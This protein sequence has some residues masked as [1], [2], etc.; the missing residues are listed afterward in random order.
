MV[1]EELQQRYGSHIARRVQHDLGRAEFNLVDLDQLP[2]YLEAR[3]EK[4]ARDY[5]MVMENPLERGN[6]RCEVLQKLWREAEDIAY[7]L[8]IAEDVSTAVRATL[9]NGN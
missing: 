8:S 4:A 2:V 9:V 1:F 5:R 6:V 3:A 7:L